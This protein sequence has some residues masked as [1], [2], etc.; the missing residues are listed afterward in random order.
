MFA[1]EPIF[2][3]R[4]ALGNIIEGFLQGS[5]SAWVRI[6]FG[7]WIWIHINVISWI[8]IRI[9]VEIQELYRLKNRTVKGH[10]CSQW[11]RGASIKWNLGGP[12][13]QWSQIPIIL[14]RNKIRLQN[15]IEVKS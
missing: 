7:S 8:P 3:A 11:R 4:E 9:R 5:G 2:I 6:I 13:D 1:K 14:M 15:R 12:V 10:G